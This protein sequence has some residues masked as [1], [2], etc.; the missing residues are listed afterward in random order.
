MHVATFIEEEI[1]V[2]M[3]QQSNSMA[4]LWPEVVIIMIFLMINEGNVDLLIEKGGG[5][6]RVSWKREEKEKSG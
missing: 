3:G 2:I 4:I 5:R 1:V 6:V